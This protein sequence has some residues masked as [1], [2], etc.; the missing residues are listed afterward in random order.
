MSTVAAVDSVVA[1]LKRQIPDLLAQ[2]Q[3]PALAVGI[4]TAA[5]IVW[6]AGFGVTAAGGSI[7]VTERTRFGVQSC[8]KM[9]TASTAMVAADNGLVCLDEPITTYLPEFRVRSRFEHHPERAITLRH[10]LSHTAGFTHEAPVGSNYLVGRASFAEH[11]RSISDTWLR[12]PVGHHYEYSNLGIDLAGYVLARVTGMSFPEIARQY[13]F[14]PLGL[15]RTT[16]ALSTIRR[17][18]DR[19]RGHGR[20]GRRPPLRVPMLAAGGLYTTVVDAC[21]YIRHHFSG[22]QP[23]LEERRLQEMYRVPFAPPDQ[24]YGYGLGIVNLTHDGI[25]IRGHSGGGFGFLSDILWA[26]DHRIGVVVLTNSTNHPLQWTLASSIFSDLVPGTDRPESTPLP[27]PDDMDAKTRARIS[28]TYIGRGL[29][30][31][32]ITVDRTPETLTTGAEEHGIRVI[33]PREF[34]VTDG[35]HDRYRILDDQHGQPKYLQRCTD[36]YTRYRDDASQ[37]PRQDDRSPEG[38]WNRTYIIRAQ[39][40]PIARCRL[41]HTDGQYLAIHTDW[42][43]GTPVTLQLTDNGHGL[44]TTSTGETLDLTQTPPTLGNIKLSPTTRA[45]P[46]LTTTTEPGE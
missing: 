39:G 29:D 45:Q 18:L 33:G 41:V 35:S 43:D 36:G 40:T 17:D 30:R 34:I 13:V 20:N 38:P 32:T 1:R 16:F 10:L 46:D 11:C 28:G 23:T 22:G 5:E 42:P 12:F 37:V 27:A 31:A 7:A 9:Y 8:S 26:P 24:P 44:L 15:D 14:D 25:P 2:H 6:S 4:C 21:R 3:I 19:A